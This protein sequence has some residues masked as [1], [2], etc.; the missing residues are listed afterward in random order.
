[1]VDA[2]SIS[3][4][5][6]LV[7]K[8]WYT[9]AMSFDASNIGW[10]GATPTDQAGGPW[11]AKESAQEHECSTR[12]R[13]CHDSSFPQQTRWNTFQTF[14]QF[15]RHIDLGLGSRTSCDIRSAPCARARELHSRLLVIQHGRQQQL[16]DFQPLFVLIHPECGPPRRDLVAACH[17][18]RLPDYISWRSDPEVQA[19]N[20]L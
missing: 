10:G 3:D 13:Q 6:M 2:E 11:T 8:E 16:N 18:A 5:A 9:V 17:D 1:V 7:Q 19:V 14:M 15:E 20:A 4:D 12:D